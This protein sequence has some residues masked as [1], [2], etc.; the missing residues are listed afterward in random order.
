MKEGW[1]CH[2]LTYPFM[3]RTDQIWNMLSPMK[4]SILIVDTHRQG[5]M[6]QCEALAVATGLPYRF[7]EPGEPAL[8]EPTLIFS[9]GKALEPAL[10]LH[11]EFGKRPGF[12]QFGRPRH[13]APHRLD[14]IILMPQDDFPSGD[15]IFQLDMPLNGADADIAAES[16]SP[17]L[18]LTSVLLGGPT[19]HFLFD[20]SDVVPLAEAAER[21][22]GANGDRIRFVPGPRTP[23]AVQ[24][25]LEARYKNT[26]NVLDHRPLKTV[27]EDSTRLIVTADSASLV[28]D[29]WRT[30]HPTW[31]YPLRANFPLVQRLKLSADRYLPA[32][33]PALIRRGWLAG[34]TDFLRW[35]RRLAQEGLI[36][37]LTPQGLKAPHWCPKKEVADPEVLYCRDRVM[38]ICH[39]VLNTGRL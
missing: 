5:E 27:L 23:Q 8:S 2:A 3:A 29:A 11:E 33:R 22:A 18:G 31:L 7:I 34:G 28:A 14:L 37:P 38:D 17:S 25:Q 24:R 39:R 12:I 16:S 19:R 13:V 26:P 32:L 10:R 36:R 21:L 9:F 30:G 6:R 20:E 1:Q 4:P 15:N 35:Y